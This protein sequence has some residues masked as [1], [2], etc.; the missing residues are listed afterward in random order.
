MSEVRVFH[1]LMRTWKGGGV[2][3]EM[4]RK[5]ENMGV[6]VCVCV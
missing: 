1:A 2:R 3:N 5:V 6:C 4:S